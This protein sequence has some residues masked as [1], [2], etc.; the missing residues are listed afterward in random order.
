LAGSSDAGRDDH[1]DVMRCFFPQ[2]KFAPVELLAEVPA[3]VAPEY[4]HG[5]IQTRTFIERIDYPTHT[6]IHKADRC[7]VALDSFL[8]LLMY[9]NFF[10]V[11]LR[12][13][14]FLA[15][16]RDIVQVIFVDVWQSNFIQRVH[17]KIFRRHVPGQMWAEKAAAKEERPIVLLA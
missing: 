16:R 10:V 8:P 2:C 7:Q 9:N 12:L 6:G 17:I 4:N 3:V 13:S 14:Y 5:I 1:Q 11:A 15:Y